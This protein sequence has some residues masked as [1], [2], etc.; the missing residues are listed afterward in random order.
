M[1]IG[2]GDT[3]YRRG[4]NGA[5]HAIA[6][7]YAVGYL[8]EDQNGNIWATSF[9]KGL[10]RI[11]ASEAAGERPAVRSCTEAH[12]LPS[13]YVFTVIET[14][15]G[16]LLAGTSEGAAERIAAASPQVPFAFRTPADLHIPVTNVR[17]LHQD[18][19]GSIW[20]GTESGVL[21][22]TTAG[23]MSYSQADGLAGST[24]QAIFESRGE[25]FAVNDH[26]RL[27]RFDG[28]RFEPV[29]T[30]VTGA[31]HFPQW[32]WGWHQ[33]I[34]R[35]QS[36]DWWVPTG[37][38]LYRFSNVA[39]FRDLRTAQPRIYKQR[40][41]LATDAVFR[42]FGD[43]HGTL[44]ISSIYGV[45]TLTSWDRRRGFVRHKVDGDS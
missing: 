13:S 9:N 26:V 16:R 22:I 3:I 38:G 23:F 39:R 7:A 32:G 17:I 1:W 37:I 18:R 2:T 20:A 25:L 5:A 44:W 12:G 42:L 36:G 15:E 31:Q 33:T 14:A 45:C 30:N 6:S 24:V 29:I 11:D 8:L 21:Q 19:D 10:L 41:G 28:T 35:D 43:S 27:S 34:L 40:D 4:P